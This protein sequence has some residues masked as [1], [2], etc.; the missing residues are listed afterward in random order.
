MDNL[1]NG[2]GCR[3]QLHRETAV[4]AECF[5][6]RSPSGLFVVSVVWLGE[7]LLS[8]SYPD[9]EAATFRANELRAGLLKYGWMP[10][11]VV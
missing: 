6:R 1:D 2:L 9:L 5:L 3:W 10:S 4:G 8:E 7:T 11:S